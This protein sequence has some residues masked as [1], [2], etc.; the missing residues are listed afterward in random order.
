[1]LKGKV[2]GNIVSTNKLDKL[3]GYKFLEIQVIEKN[4]LTDKF[5]VAVD[6]TVSAGIGEEVLVTTGS[7]ARVAVGD[8]NSPVDA[9]VVGVVDKK[10]S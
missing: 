5:I 9:V 2:I 6:R 1:M 3:V 4:E 8:A 7:S 10:Q